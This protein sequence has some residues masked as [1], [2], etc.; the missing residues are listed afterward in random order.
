LTEWIVAVDRKPVIAGVMAI[1]LLLASCSSDR[2]TRGVYEGIQNRN[3]ALKTP[4]EKMSTPSPPA[5]PE[6]R[7][8]RDRTQDKPQE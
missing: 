3:E 5:Y 7:K 2:M 4:A 1:C 8:E 6:Y